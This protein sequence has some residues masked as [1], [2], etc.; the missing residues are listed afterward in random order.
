MRTISSFLDPKF[1]EQFTIQ[2]QGVSLLPE[3]YQKIKRRLSQLQS[4][5]PANSTLH[6]KLSSKEGHV[7]AELLSIN[8]KYKFYSRKFD[9]DPFL[10]FLK[11]EK[12]IYRQ[13]QKW[14]NNRFTVESSDRPFLVHTK[15]VLV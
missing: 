15:E 6:L 4:R 7:I 1:T 3:T 9:I 13:L 12:D 5:A 10:S 8:S 11:V 2:E 14:K